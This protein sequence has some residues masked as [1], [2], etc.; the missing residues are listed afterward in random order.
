[1]GDKSPQHDANQGLAR[2]YGE[3]SMDVVNARLVAMGTPASVGL[4]KILIGPFKGL[5]TIQN[6]SERCRKCFGREGC[7]NCKNG[8]ST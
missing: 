8:T 7:P 6:S 5:P 4:L 3:M 1:M 2:R